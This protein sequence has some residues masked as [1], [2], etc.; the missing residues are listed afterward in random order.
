MQEMIPRITTAAPGPRRRAVA[1]AARDA[2]GAGEDPRVSRMWDEAE[3]SYVDIVICPDLPDPGLTSCST[4]SLHETTNL[5]DG[6]DV[7]VELAGTYLSDQPI[8][9]GILATAAL[10]VINDAWLA[11]PDVVVRDAV[12]RY[13]AQAQMKH[14][15]LGDPFPC[16]RT[17]GSAAG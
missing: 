7:R 4:L 14:L 3:R 13:D 6:R 5:L 17:R 8:F 9:I 15:L 1:R 12:S 16:A 10:D 2:F 11:A